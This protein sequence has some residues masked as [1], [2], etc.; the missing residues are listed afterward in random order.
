MLSL[1]RPHNQHQVCIKHPDANWIKPRALKRFAFQM[2]KV[3]S[4]GKSHGIIQAK[5]SIQV[6]GS[7]LQSLFQHQLCQYQACICTFKSVHGRCPSPQVQMLSQTG[8]PGSTDV[9]RAPWGALR[10]AYG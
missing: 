10:P 7:S 3:R 8:S 6:L 9:G 1:H 5:W 4:S 2:T